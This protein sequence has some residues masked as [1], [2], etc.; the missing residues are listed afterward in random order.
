MS[1][2]AAAIGVDGCRAGWVA[3]IA[4]TD[5]HD[6]APSAPVARTELRLY[7]N[8]EGGLRHLVEECEAAGAGAGTPKAAPVILAVDVPMGLP[9]RAGLR[10]CDH[11]ARATLGQR[12]PCVFP[13]PDRELLG[14]S[15]EQARDVVTARR[16]AEPTAGAHP[17]MT[18]QAMAIAPKIA[19]ADALLTA[20]PDRQR[21]LVEVHPELSFRALA[22]ELGH[23]SA[24]SGL[25]RKKRSAGRALRRELIAAV[26]DDALTQAD[27]APW[28]GTV[29]GRDDILDAY[30]GLWSALRYRHA[31]G[32]A[33]EKLVILG[34]GT[35]AA[36]K[37]L[38]QMIV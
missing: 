7:T 11:A 36:H 25:P 29:V 15:F 37:L 13:A 17:I 8:A 4:Y 21:W 24:T 5:G 6:P 1:E 16:A 10:T 38:A 26:F 9:R 18:R 27:A 19:E 30:A 31:N 3:A 14:L 32:V 35:P 28:T 23:P 20:A 33:G 12:W 34:D 2:R 22:L